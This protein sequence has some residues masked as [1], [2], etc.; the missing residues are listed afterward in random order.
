MSRLHKNRFLIARRA[1]QLIILF[2]F[3]GAANWGWTLLKGNLSAAKVLDTFYIADPY[4]VVQM[5]FAGKIPSWDIIIG[6]LIITVL[7]AL[8]VGRSFCSWVCPMNIVT[9]TARWLKNKLGLKSSRYLKI[10]RNLRYW[11]VGLSLFMS[12]ILGVA[13]FEFISPVSV[14]HRAIIYGAGMSWLIVLLIFLLD[15]LIK[16]YLWCGYLCPLG[17]FYSALSHKSVVKIYHDVDNCDKDC[18]ECKKVCPEVQVMDII[19]K[20]KGVIKSGECT[21]CGRCIES[22]NYKALKFSIFKKTKS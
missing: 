11:I 13:A 6:A 20:E 5:L 17:G 3:I 4:A 8:L 15:L 14:L 7:Y 9:D 1:V 22:C 2:L 18:V 16:D 21:N 19:K 10:D 12:I